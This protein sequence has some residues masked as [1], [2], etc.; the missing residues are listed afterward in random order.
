[1]RERGGREREGERE[2]ERREQKNKEKKRSEGER[3]A[4]AR[5]S[6]VFPPP[7]RGYLL[8]NGTF[9]S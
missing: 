3:D 2:R 5:G 7:F 4:L 6:T 1:M 9:A 8:R